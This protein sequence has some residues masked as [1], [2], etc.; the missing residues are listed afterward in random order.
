MHSLACKFRV[1]LNFHHVY[2]SLGGVFFFLRNSKL[3]LHLY[4]CFAVRFFSGFQLKW[5]RGMLICKI[6][7]K[8][9][10][11]LKHEFIFLLCLNFAFTSVGIPFWRLLSKLLN[12]YS[13]IFG[14][15]CVLFFSSSEEFR[16]SVL[17]RFQRLLPRLHHD[18]TTYI[19]EM[20]L[21]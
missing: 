20:R 19:S 11:W 2:A 6:I 16:A 7:M 14:I 9:W 4:G 17:D 15:E 13:N 12:V 5:L 3:K 18:L 10:K 8:V 21:K 1:A